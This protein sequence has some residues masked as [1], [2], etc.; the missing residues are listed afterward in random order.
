[1]RAV[2]AWVLCCANCALFIQQQQ[3]ALRVKRRRGL[4]FLFRLRQEGLQALLLQRTEEEGPSEPPLRLF[5]DYDKKLM[6][7]GQSRLPLQ[8][9]V[10]AVAAGV[11]AGPQ[12]VRTTT[13]TA[14]KINALALVAEAEAAIAITIVTSISGEIRKKAHRRRA[15]GTMGRPSWERTE[16]G[17]IHA[18]SASSAP[19]NTTKMGASSLTS[20]LRT[21]SHAWTTTILRT[22]V[23]GVD[24]RVDGIWE[25]WFWTAF[26][27]FVFSFSFFFIGLRCSCA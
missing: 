10:G 27:R 2:P 16:S 20:T 19:L 5:C 25:R 22:S 26:G 24:R 12:A 4:S 13:R 7:Y 18:S 6:R 9:A 11:E 3:A 1:M 15:A 14:A 17:P 8:A 21:C 23:N